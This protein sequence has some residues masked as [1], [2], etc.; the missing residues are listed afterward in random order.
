MKKFLFLSILMLL[1]F[2][3]SYGAGV[4]GIYSHKV[5]NFAP[6]ST[7]S[8]DDGLMSLLFMLTRF[9][10]LGICMLIGRSLMAIKQK[11]MF[12]DG[13]MLGLSVALSITVT[14]HFSDPIV[15]WIQM[16]HCVLGL[17]IGVASAP[18]RKIDKMIHWLW[19]NNMLYII[20]HE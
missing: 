5:L 8:P 4:P 13:V 15:F 20:T 7:L 12:M 1:F 11:Q 3:I 9:I 19:H 16:G 14:I 17:V 18:Q 6:V 10:G 2:N